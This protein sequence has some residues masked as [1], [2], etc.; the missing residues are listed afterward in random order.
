ME[1]WVLKTD[2]DGKEITVKDVQQVLLEMMKDI[3]AV[4]KKHDIPYILS[5]GSALGAYRHQGFIPWDDDIDIAMMEHDYRRFLDIA[6]KEMSDDYVIHCYELNKCYNVTIPTMK[7]RKKGTYVQ[8]V[9]KLLKNKCKDSDGLFI[10][11]FVYTPVSDKLWIDLPFRVFNTLLMP[12]IILFENLRINPIPL[13]SLYVLIAKIYGI[14]NKGSK[15]IGFELTWT[16]HS[17]LKPYRF[18]KADLFPTQDMPFEDASFSVAGNIEAYLTRAIGP[19]FSN[20][21]PVEHRQPKHIVDIV[22][23]GD[24]P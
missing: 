23:D 24:S 18:L 9:N 8:E 22:L 15:H 5:G 7:I 6:V 12:W 20:L 10:D 11:V 13:K 4:C 19:D 16:F 17:P 1:K 21:P 2:V 14:I 3:D